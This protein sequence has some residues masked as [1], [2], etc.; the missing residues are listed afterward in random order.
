MPDSFIAE[1]NK[2]GL[3]SKRNKAARKLEFLNRRKEKFDW[4]NGETEADDLVEDD[5]IYPDIP[6]EFPG[7]L[8]DRGMSD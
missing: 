6:A 4:D 2:W 7:L 3:R 8:F 5:V 1:V